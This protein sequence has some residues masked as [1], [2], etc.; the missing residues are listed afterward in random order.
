MT[1]REEI[2]WQEHKR[3]NPLAAFADRSKGR[4]LRR[5][6]GRKMC[7]LVISGTLTGLYIAKRSGV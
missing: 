3:L 6:P 7:V 2:E 4:P 5:N 1:V